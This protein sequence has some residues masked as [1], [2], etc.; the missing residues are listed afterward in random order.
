V[1]KWLF[2]LVVAAGAVW[3]FT[4]KNSAP[5]AAQDRTPPETQAPAITSAPEP[6]P[7][8]PAQTSSRE[9]SEEQCR[10]VGGRIISGMG[11]VVGAPAGDAN[12]H[13]SPSEMESFCASSGKRYVRELNAC[14]SS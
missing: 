13:V 11:C 7:Q 14:V 3:H 4:G 1:T 9:P 12:P 6:T 5:D 8:P 10:S 2:V